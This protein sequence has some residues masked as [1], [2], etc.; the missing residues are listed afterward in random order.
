MLELYQ[1]SA[2]YNDLME[3][4]ESLFQGIADCLLGSRKLVYQG[5]EYD[6]SKK[7][8]RLT[9]EEIILANNPDLDPMSR[10]DANYLPRVCDQM[11]IGYRAGD[12]PGKLQIKLSENTAKHRH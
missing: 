8:A 10:R 6:L 11:K 9:I 3:M 2:D 1:A 5:T 7:F 4:I 12:R